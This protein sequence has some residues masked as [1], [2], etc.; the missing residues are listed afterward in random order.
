MI[1]I[2]KNAGF[3]F[4]VRRATDT[5]EALIKEKNKSTIYIL[6]K[7]IH[8]EEYI[9]YLEENGVFEISPD[10]IDE[11]YKRAISGEK[12]TVVV[13]THGIE[14]NIYEKLESCEK[15]TENFTLVNCTCPY[16]TKIHK[17]A[18]ENSDTKEK[19]EIFI[20]I[21]KNDHPEVMSIMSHVVGEGYVF[22]NGQELENFLTDLKKRENFDE[23]F[24]NMAAQTTQKLEEWE[25]CQ[26]ILKKHCTNAK[27]FATIC[28]VTDIRQREADELSRKCDV[29]I[30]VG[31]KTS[32]NTSKLA[33]VCEKNCTKT[34]WVQT[35]RDIPLDKIG[36]AKNIGITAGASTPDS[37]I[38]EVK[39]TMSEIMENQIENQIENED[40]GKMLE[41][42]ES[43]KLYTGATVTGTVMG[44][45]DTEIRLDLGAKVTGIITK[46]QITDSNDVNLADLFK[47]GDSVDAKVISKS[48]RDGIAIL[49]K[50]MVDSVKNL[51]K[52]A[53]YASTNETVEAKVVEITKGG[54]VCDV[55]SV[56]VFIPASMTGIKKGDDMSVLAGTTQQIKIVEVKDNKR[57]AIGSI[58][59]VIN[60]QK[61][62]AYEEKKAKEEALW[63]SLEV[64]MEFEGP[65]KN[66]TSYGAFVDL[67][68][69]DGLVHKSELSWNMR[70]APSSVVKTGEIIKVYIKAIDNENKKISLGYKT[71]ESKP[72][73]I[74][75]AQYNVGDVVIVKI[76]NVETYG[77]FA[78]IIPGVDGLI[79]I[80]QIA[81]RKIESVASVLKKGDSVSALIKEIDDEKEKVSLSMRALLE[82]NA[83]EEVAEEVVEEAAEEVAE[84]VAE[85]NADE[86][87]E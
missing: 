2:A 80:S 73:N 44:I 81:D 49:S 61:K 12:I 35:S 77:A 40:F 55:D 87:A 5:V 85:D 72:W 22:A 42:M 15:T 1:T 57:E 6:G 21:G 58:R 68:G 39:R 69:I 82:D 78:E 83:E 18:N 54:V 10:Q 62:A 28:S 59:A 70:V 4:G 7:L 51:A 50:K 64:G 20:L 79:H 13:R 86:A 19:K 8:N 67:G 31:G 14:K 25:K 53:E 32:S 84:E 48:D 36:H 3:C 43:V 45:T 23:I 63:N 60:E 47:I 75:K 76:R 33:Q 74:F 46:D 65:V 71:E 29:M 11:L 16:V 34:Y 17:I 30:V 38:Q 27:I 9:K 41:E 66:I 56:R 52:I 26:K 24:V 37:L